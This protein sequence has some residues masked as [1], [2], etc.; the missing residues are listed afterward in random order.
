VSPCFSRSVERVRLLGSRPH[1]HLQG[2]ALVDGALAVGHTVGVD[3]AL[4]HP[5]RVDLPSRAP[6]SSAWHVPWGSSSDS[7]EH[8]QTAAGRPLGLPLTLPSGNQIR[9]RQLDTGVTH[10]GRRSGQRR[11]SWPDP[12]RNAGVARAWIAPTNAAAGHDAFSTSAGSRLSARG[13]FARRDE[14]GRQCPI[15][16]IA[17]REPRELCA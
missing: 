11:A 6:G 12:S 2:L 15:G 9:R 14:R 7:C 13:E 4:E 8:L 17:E 5:S 16:E 10:H 1:H 3:G